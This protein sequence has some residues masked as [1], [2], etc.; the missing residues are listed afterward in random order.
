[1]LFIAGCNE[2]V[3]SLNPEKKF[4][5]DLS[6]RFRETGTQ[7]MNTLIPKN[8]VIEPKARLL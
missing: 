6:C 3:F 1:L 4:G 2:Q 8:V 7:K 5:A